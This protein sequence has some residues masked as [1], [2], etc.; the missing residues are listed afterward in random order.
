VASDPDPARLRAL[1]A[2]LKTATKG[3]ERAP[4]AT[5]RGFS[6]G[7]VAWRMVIELATG[8]LVGVGIGYGLDVLFGTLPVFLAIFSLVGFAAGVRTMLGTAREVAAKAKTD[9]AASQATAV[10]DDDEEE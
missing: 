1:E 3:P 4:S 5:A 9:P 10:R 7:E 2:R 6:Q 8:I